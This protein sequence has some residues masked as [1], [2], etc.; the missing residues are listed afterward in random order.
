MQLQKYEEVNILFFTTIKPTT[1][2]IFVTD[3]TN[4]IEWQKYS[5]ANYP[6]SHM[7]TKAALE[8]KVIIEK[9]EDERDRLYLNSSAVLREA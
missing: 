8:M 2:V 3:S 9:R 4:A 7:W 5:T 1:N 6:S